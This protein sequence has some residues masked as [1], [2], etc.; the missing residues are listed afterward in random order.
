MATLYLNGVDCEA[1]YGF[2]LTSEG[3]ALDGAVVLPGEV[4]IPSVPGA[5]FVGPGRVPVREFRLSGVI[6]A[7]TFA[8]ARASLRTMQA[9]LEQGEV[10]VRLADRD[11]ISIRAVCTGVRPVNLAPQFVQPAVQ[12][13]LAFRAAVP[14]WRDTQALP[15]RFG[16]TSSPTPMP[17]G[18]ASVAPDLW[19]FGPAANPQ[20]KG[21]DHRGNELWSATFT[22]TLGANDALR[23]V[24]SAFDMTVWKYVAS[25]T[26][27]LD[28]TLLT[29]GVF[30][31]PLHSSQGTYQYLQWPMLGTTAARGVA[32]YPRCWV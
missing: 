12:V 31:R 6:I 22:I 10:V 20:V 26:G 3:N 16:S 4:E 32:V 25:P 21:Y 13:E 30:P 18:S 27:V 9:L 17:M 2:Q 14:Y 23:I 8:T 28:D 5:F 19:L 29:A 11:D 15:Y 24:T 1:V 7:S